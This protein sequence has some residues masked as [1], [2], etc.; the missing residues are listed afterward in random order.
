MNAR[1]DRPVGDRTPRPIYTRCNRIRT[2]P[3]TVFVWATGSPV[4]RPVVRSRA[5]HRSRCTVCA[6]RHSYPPPSLSWRAISRLIR[7]TPRS[8]SRRRHCTTERLGSGS[9]KQGWIRVVS[10]RVV[11][12]TGIV[13]PSFPRHPHFHLNTSGRQ[14]PTGREAPNAGRASP[15]TTP[16]F[17]TGPFG[18]S[19]AGSVDFRDE[20]VDRRP[21]TPGRLRLRSMGRRAIT[22]RNVS[23]FSTRRVPT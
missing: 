15:G 5:S 16:R 7:T 20:S 17:S 4:D 8:A 1:M 22:S 18:S 9:Q 3:V 6:L 21:T 13:A 2:P 10:K 19:S 11:S 23:L 12:P 14:M